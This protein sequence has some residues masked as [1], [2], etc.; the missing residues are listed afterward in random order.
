MAARPAKRQKRLVVPSSLPH[1]GSDAPDG[2][3]S[4]SGRIAA[5]KTQVEAEN[6]K[7]PSPFKGDSKRGRTASRTTRASPKKADAVHGTQANGRSIATFF[8]AAAHSTLS[9]GPSTSVLDEPD[10]PD[11]DLI[12]DDSLDDD[13][14]STQAGHG[15]SLRRKI[16][17]D[18][19]QMSRRFKAPPGS[20]TPGEEPGTRLQE[21]DRR[22]WAEKYGPTSLE[23][24]AVHRKKVADVRA[25]LQDGLRGPTRQKLLILKGPAGTGKTTA[26]HLLSQAM[27]VEILEWRN[28]VGSVATSEGYSSMSAQFEE[29]IGRSATYGALALTEAEGPPVQ[30]TSRR[31]IVLVEEFPNTF[32][33]A[34]TA[35]QSFRAAVHQ[36]L[37]SAAAAATA[38]WRSPASLTDSSPP[39]VMIIS[40]TLLTTSSAAADSFTAHRLLGSDILHHPAVSVVEFNPIARTLLTKA[41]GLIVQKE[42]RRSGRRKT[43]GP[44]VLEKLAEVGDI[45][46]AVGSLEFLCL[47]G[48]EEEDWGASVAFGASKR[49]R[50]DA[51]ALTKMERESLELVTQREASLGIFHAVGKVV[52]NKRDDPVATPA[53][54]SPETLLPDHLSSHARPKL[55]QVQIDELIDE[56][57]TDTSTFLAALH[58]NY[59]PSCDGPSIEAMFDAINGCVDGLSNSDLLCLHWK[60]D[61]GAGRGGGAAPGTASDA[62]RQD[63]MSFQVAVRS[64]LFALPHPVKRRAFTAGA[65]ST[66]SRSGGGVGGGRSND[67]FKMFYPTS[68]RLWRQTEETGGLVDTWI[69]RFQ[70]PGGPLDRV[71]T[72]SAGTDRATTAGVVQSWTSA[73]PGFS[74]YRVPPTGDSAPASPE[75]AMSG[76]GGR[77]DRQEMIL[78]RLPYLAKIA[79]KTSLDPTPRRQLESITTFRGIDG[80][81]DAIPD[82]ED[83]ANGTSDWATDRPVEDGPL[84]ARPTT[85]P[86]DPRKQLGSTLGPARPDEQS[87]ARLV[88]SDDDIE[89]DD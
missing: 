47:R 28:P 55:S 32:T 88:L 68:S 50:T 41:L 83:E 26:I 9:T 66:G 61:L 44:R 39:M 15:S 38:K 46:S 10:E 72:T 53:M 89:D 4:I 87:I 1:H 21:L 33:R 85:K 67:V 63:E 86:R 45:R 69:R 82:D 18:V 54:T 42:S 64:M 73:A 34:S 16:P 76:M 36:Y 48:D 62:M 43:P 23:E 59:L 2:S 81:N 78:E 65:L 71:S 80:Q 29:F 77:A 25:W 35:L 7:P 14:P 60:S 5:K 75:S 52:Y 19:I 27:D 22:P 70:Q 57:G 6:V 58:E 3:T 40:E 37:A 79:P 12:Q 8:A 11:E 49:P 30:P 17:S 74:G 20:V 84:A 56:T 51:S 24:L 13:L 31:K